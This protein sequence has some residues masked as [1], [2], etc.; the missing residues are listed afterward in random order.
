MKAVLFDV[1][2]TLI[3]CVQQT[4]AAWRRTLRSFGHDISKAAL[5]RQSGRDT[6]EMLELLLPDTTKAQRRLGNTAERADERQV[7]LP[8]EL[9]LLFRQLAS[10]QD[11]QRRFHGCS[12][13]A[14]E[15]AEAYVIAHEVGYHVQNLLG[16]LPKVQQAQQSLDKVEANQVQVQVELQADCLGDLPWQHL[17]ESRALLARSAF[18]GTIDNLPTQ[19]AAHPER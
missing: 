8:I 6:A 4:I 15:F 12:G 13:K 5:Q 19:E 3:D 17:A 9:T 2:G 7:L 1:E 14:C 18:G 16:I 11:L 10:F